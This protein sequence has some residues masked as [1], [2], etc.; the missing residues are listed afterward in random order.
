MA[1]VAMPAFERLRAVAQLSVTP[2]QR[3]YNIF[4]A[5]EGSAL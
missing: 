3:F 2:F 1:A 5:D 4:V